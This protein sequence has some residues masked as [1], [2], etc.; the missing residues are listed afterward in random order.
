M[1]INQN[2]LKWEYICAKTKGGQRANKTETNVRLTHIPS[3]ITVTVNGRSQSRN[4]KR[5]LIMLQHKLEQAEENKKAKGKKEARDKSLK[6]GVIRTYNYKRNEV[7]D[8]RTGRKADLK[9]VM[10]GE[11]DLIKEKRPNMRFL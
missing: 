7:I 6:D 8:H 1:D 2:D 11:L 4:K 10:N 9:K 3:G 5:A